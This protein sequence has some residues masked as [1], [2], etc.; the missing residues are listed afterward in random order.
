MM[1]YSERKEGGLLVMEWNWEKSDWP[2]FRYKTE[3]LEPLEKRFLLHSGEF[4]GACKHIGPDD[5]ETLKIELIS[6]EAVKTSEIEGEILNRDSVQSSLRHQLG[7]GAEQP[8]VA[9]AERGISEMMVDLHRNFADPLTDPLLFSW[10][11]ML[12][13]G[14]S[15]GVIGGY[16]TRADAM[17]V[18]PRPHY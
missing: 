3:A 9:P 2:E 15:F 8:G 16:H 13:S 17:H 7:L 4:I 5:Q 12:L 1:G 14:K 10:H 11:K 18:V 6:D